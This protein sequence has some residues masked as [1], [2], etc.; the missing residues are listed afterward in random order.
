MTGTNCD[1]FTHKSSRLY[2][3]HLVSFIATYIKYVTVRWMCGC[4]YIRRM[5]VCISVLPSDVCMCACVCVCACPYIRRFLCLCMY[6]HRM[7]VC[8]SVH[9]SDVCASLYLRRMCVHLSVHPS[10]MCVSV[11]LCTSPANNF[12][13]SPVI[14]LTKIYP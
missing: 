1:L 6:I 14:I 5:C 2:L 8:L 7:C 11:P 9:L 12:L 4:L 3:N 10:D 13:I